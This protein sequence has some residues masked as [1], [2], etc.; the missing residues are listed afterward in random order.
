[1]EKFKELKE[2]F[3]EFIKTDLPRIAP[4][5]LFEP[6]S[7]IV[8]LE[9]KRVRP[10][11]LLASN[12][13]FGPIQRDALYAALAIELF[14][15]FS[16]MH[17]DIMDK[18]ETRRGLPTVHKKFNENSAILSGDA[19]L[20]LS[21][22]LLEKIQN[23]THFHS[24]FKLYNKTALEICIG[25]QLDMNFENELMVSEPEY[26]MMIE[27]KTA[28]LLAT[29]MKIGAIIANASIEDQQAFY[30]FGLNI[31]MA[32]Q[33][34]DDILDT[35]GESA[36]VGKRI[37]GDICNNKKTLLFIFA[38][39][40]AHK[41]HKELLLQWTQTSEFLPE[42]VEE[43]R[44]IFIDSGAKDYAIKKRD[45]YYQ[46]ALESVRRSTISDNDKEYLISFAQKAVERVK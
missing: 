16:L 1:M 12:L 29:S 14:H 24:I 8:H 13:C 6:Y 19:L 11:M 38:L 15:N 27:H 41:V 31:G 46:Q 26:L 18:S 42:K 21:Y 23:P 34:Q 33:I 39:A 30:D 36:A 9:G 28:V 37:G 32:F 22:Q 44:Q 25:Q 20:I 7:Y 2:K 40:N 17:D 3:E 5:E 45:S 4:K 43:V 10:V 35:F